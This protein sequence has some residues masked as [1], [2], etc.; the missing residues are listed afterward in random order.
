VSSAFLHLY[1]RLTIARS[2]KRNALPEFT[3]ANVNYRIDFLS[4]VNET[5]QHAVDV[6]TPVVSSFNLTFDAFGTN[7]DVKEN[8]VRLSTEDA[9]EPAPI[10]PTHGESWDFV[11][12]TARQVFDNAIVGPSG[13]IGEF[14]IFLSRF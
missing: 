8:V 2:I 5:L 7:P 3:S 12:G 11:S 10:S 13:M 1:T 9:I 6:L 4:S 14:T